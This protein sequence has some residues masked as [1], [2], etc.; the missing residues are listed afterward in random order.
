[1]FYNFQTSSYKERA[2]GIRPHLFLKLRTTEFVNFP[3]KAF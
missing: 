1:M 3:I 2:Q